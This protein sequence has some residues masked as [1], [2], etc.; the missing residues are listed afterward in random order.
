MV[1]NVS[2]HYKN[3]KLRNPNSA[4]SQLREFATSQT[5]EGGQKKRVEMQK[6]M[7]FIWIMHRLLVPGCSPLPG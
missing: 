6:A 7:S 5:S 1:S 2:F 3:R 4:S